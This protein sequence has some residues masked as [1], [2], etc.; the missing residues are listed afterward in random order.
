MLPA[1]SRHE[2]LSWLSLRAF[3]EIAHRVPDYVPLIPET[4]A[5]REPQ[6]GRQAD[7]GPPRSIDNCRKHVAASRSREHLCH[8]FTARTQ[9][10]PGAPNRPS[11]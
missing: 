5:C 11:A 6:A 10:P 2:A 7:Q 4:A 1:T 8:Q 9:N 3:Q